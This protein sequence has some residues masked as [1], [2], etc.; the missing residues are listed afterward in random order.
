MTGYFRC[1]LSTFALAC[2]LVFTGGEPA[3]HASSL[4]AATG[5]GRA[6]TGGGPQSADQMSQPWN[7]FRT[8]QL[9]ATQLPGQIAAQTAKRTPPPGPNPAYTSPITHAEAPRA[10]DPP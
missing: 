3:G 10:A 1:L 9:K 6:A 7:Q 2:V 5:G 4:P 8:P